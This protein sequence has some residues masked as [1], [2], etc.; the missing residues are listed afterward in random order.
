[1]AVAREAGPQPRRELALAEGPEREGGQPVLKRG[2]LQVRQCVQVRYHPATV[3]RFDGRV[4]DRREVCPEVLY[5]LRNGG[6]PYGRSLSD[7][8][9]SSQ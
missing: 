3:R 7:L 4:Q 6:L 1:M 9:T 8:G 5:V 2:F